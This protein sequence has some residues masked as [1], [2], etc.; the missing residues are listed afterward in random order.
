MENKEAQESSPF[1]LTCP[2]PL[3]IEENK[4]WLYICPQ[5]LEDTNTP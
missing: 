5:Q 3:K 4:T 2:R 1:Y